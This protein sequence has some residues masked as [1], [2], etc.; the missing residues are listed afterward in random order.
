MGSSSRSF[1][2]NSGCNVVLVSFNVDGRQKKR[3]SPIPY[4]GHRPTKQMWQISVI[5]RSTPERTFLD[6]YPTTNFV[7]RACTTGG[8]LTRPGTRTHVGRSER[9]LARSRAHETEQ[10]DVEVRFS[11]RPCLPELGLG[12]PSF[13]SRSRPP[14][15]F[16]E[17]PGPNAPY[18]GSRCSIATTTRQ[19]WR[20]DPG[21]DLPI[22]RRSLQASKEQG[23]ASTLT[24]FSSWCSSTGADGTSPYSYEWPS[25]SWFS[26]RHYEH[27]PRMYARDVPC[28]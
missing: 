23:R 20:C 24:R 8:V 3:T 16:M 25:F 14:S 21:C 9:Q 12:L 10:R 1:A 4:I 28:E 15:L 5:I 17:Y 2:G 19:F 26:P 13:Y 18:A 7:E 11:V 22:C 27:L 6:L